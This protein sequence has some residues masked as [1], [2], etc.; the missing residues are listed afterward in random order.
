[1][2]QKMVDM[3]A[4]A[5]KIGGFGAQMRMSILTM[6]ASPKAMETPDSAENIDKFRKALEI[7]RKENQ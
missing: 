6:V 1:M 3:Y 5:K 7:I 2:G 4:E